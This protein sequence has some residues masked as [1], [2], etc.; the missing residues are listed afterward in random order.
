MRTAI[1]LALMEDAKRRRLLHERR[2]ADIAADHKR[3]DAIDA[4]AKKKAA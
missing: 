4:K 2:M 1:V 3:Q